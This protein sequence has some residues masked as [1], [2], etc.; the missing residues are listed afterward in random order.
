MA[1][2]GDILQGGGQDQAPVSPTA[3][4]A[5]MSGQGQ[6]Q[7]QPGDNHTA[8]VQELKSWRDNPENAMALLQGALGVLGTDKRRGLAAALTNGLAQGAAYKGR[9]GKLKQDQEQQQF[10]N[11][12][13]Q[14]RTDQ[15][16]R[17]LDQGDR[18]LDIE[19]QRAQSYDRQTRGAA[20]KAAK[21]TK[22]MKDNQVATNL[23]K[24]ADSLYPAPDV[25]DFTTTEEYLAAKDKRDHQWRNW[26]YKAL[27]NSSID[28]VQVIGEMPTVMDSFQWTDATMQKAFSNPDIVSG[29]KADYPDEAS[30]AWIDQMEKVYSTIHESP[31]SGQ[32]GKA[33][34]TDGEGNPVV[35][36]SQQEQAHQATST[37]KGIDVKAK[38]GGAKGRGFLKKRNYTNAK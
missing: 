4:S 1:M 28:P 2:I 29:L 5:T 11:Q 24:T 32:T 10:E 21:D 14:A 34:K 17:K 18:G 13:N 9:V 8:W 23:R 35:P 15:A 6:P 3:A 26:M 27:K 12:Q 33:P 25:L 31:E 38:M 36:K 19:A 7:Q 16:N 22:S 20:A 37:A 30:Q